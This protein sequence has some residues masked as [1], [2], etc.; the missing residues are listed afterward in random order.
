[1]SQELINNQLVSV[2][3][4]SMQGGRN[5]NQDYTTAKVL[6]K[7]HTVLVVCDGMGGMAG[8]RQASFLA[9]HTIVDSI[10]EFFYRQDVDEAE[11]PQPEELLKEV[12]QRANLAVFNRGHEDVDLFGMG[13]TAVVVYL[14]PEKAYVA[15][16]GDSR[17]YQLRNGKK[18]FRTND[19]SRVFELVAAGIYSEEQARTAPGNNIITR[20][21]GVRKSIEVEIHQLS[22]KKGDRFLLCSDGIWNTMPEDQLLNLFNS[23]ENIADVVKKTTQIVNEM[24][25]NS[26]QE[27]DN[28]TLLCAETH[29]DS[30][31]QEKT[32][33]AKRFL[34]WLYKDTKPAD[35]KKKEEASNKKEKSEALSQ[36]T[37][38]QP[39][40][41]QHQ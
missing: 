15:H 12:F 22:Y 9:A 26:Q 5:E 30:T 40:D 2:W 16:T 27:Y 20:A 35:T 17:C 3:S 7:T 24:G 13:S 38:S 32:S 39:T 19:H 36:Q 14:T 37:A 23:E 4:E 25:I 18:I 33:L 31:F 6:G 10:A 1:M 34:H 21:M 28:L 41:S 29:T 8:G 11:K